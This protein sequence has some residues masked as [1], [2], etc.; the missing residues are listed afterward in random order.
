MAF[1]RRAHVASSAGG[2]S[3]ATPA[4][5]LTRWC[6]TAQ[7]RV[8]GQGGH[9]MTAAARAAGQRHSAR[10]SEHPHAPPHVRDSAA[11]ERRGPRNDPAAAWPFAAR[12]DSS[13]PTRRGRGVA[14]WHAQT[15]AHPRRRHDDGKRGSIRQVVEWHE[16]R[17]VRMRIANGH[18]ASVDRAAM[19]EH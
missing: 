1:E 5:S 14:G 6:V 12:H 4:A 3:G 17:G 18:Y 2:V 13:L 8:T 9:A 19:S 16:N 10:W 11:P 15:S 7:K